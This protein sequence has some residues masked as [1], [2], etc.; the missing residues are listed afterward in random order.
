MSLSFVE[1][2]ISCKFK[3]L[4]IL[5]F[6][7]IWLNISLESLGSIL[8]NFSLIYLLIFIEKLFLITF[9]IIFTNVN[10]SME[11]SNLLCLL[12][13]VNT[14]LVSEYNILIVELLGNYFLCCFKNN[15]I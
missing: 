15:I 9:L 8:V 7:L 14:F 4:N 6:F 3:G 11:S 2:L 13:N 1:I 10:V 5:K 12:T